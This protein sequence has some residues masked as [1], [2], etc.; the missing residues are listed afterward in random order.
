M[1]LNLFI[2]YY[3]LL[4]TVF[5]AICILRPMLLMPLIDLDGFDPT[6]QHLHSNERM[7]VILFVLVCVWPLFVLAI[8]CQ[9]WNNRD[10]D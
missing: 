3:L 1:T 2:T 4:G 5:W 10:D 7:L 8:A 9:I 6:E